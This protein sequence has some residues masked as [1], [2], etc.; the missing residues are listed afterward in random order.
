MHYQFALKLSV[1]L[2]L[3]FSI[4][5]SCIAQ[6]HSGWT[7]E[8]MISSSPFHLSLPFEHLHY[9]RRPCVLKI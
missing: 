4:E 9:T 8:L 2:V 6:W 7:T 5:T 1:G 3:K